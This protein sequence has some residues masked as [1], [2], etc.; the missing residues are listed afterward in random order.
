MCQFTI[1]TLQISRCPLSSVWRL[2]VSPCL[3]AFLLHFIR[4]IFFVFL[5]LSYLCERSM[6]RALEANELQ[7]LL[8]AFALVARFQMNAPPC[9]HV[10]VRAHLRL[11][12]PL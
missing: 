12:V 11:E 6:G 3:P 1:I 5:V 2:W 10:K 8:A 9:V 7:F 4:L